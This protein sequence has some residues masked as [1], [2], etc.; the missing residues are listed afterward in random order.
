[1]FEAR[2][3]LDENLRP[4]PPSAACLPVNHSRD[5]LSHSFMTM[6]LLANKTISFTCYRP[7][8][9][10]INKAADTRFS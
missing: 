4:S 8:M 5:A 9:A 2:A 1:M 7:N 10:V 6:R 3:W